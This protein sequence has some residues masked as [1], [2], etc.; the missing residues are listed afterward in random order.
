MIHERTCDQI[1]QTVVIWG[2]L[3]HKYKG[4]RS[5]PLLKKNF[6]FLVTDMCVHVCV[7]VC[8]S[9]RK[10]E[11]EKEK[12]QFV[13]PLIYAYIG[14][15]LNVPW[16]GGRTWNLGVSGQCS[17]QLSY[18]A[19]AGKT[20]LLFPCTLSWLDMSLEL[21]PLSGPQ[22]EGAA[23]TCVESVIRAMGWTWPSGWLHLWTSRHALILSAP[24]PELGFFFFFFFPES[25]CYDTCG[26]EVLMTY[27]I[28]SLQKLSTRY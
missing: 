14:C 21:K 5:F 13:F 17:N 9:E 25:I 4:R 22:P 15:F 24:L 6:F 16:L 11:R 27:L 8:V 7:F 12:H 1:L 23:R 3:F 19:R 18:L 10:R 20:F 28:Y 2:S 26:D